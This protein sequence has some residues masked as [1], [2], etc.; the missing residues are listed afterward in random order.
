MQSRILL[1]IDNEVGF[2]QS[3]YPGIGGV[4]VYTEK[5]EVG[6]RWYDAHG[7]APKYAFGHGLS[8][9]TFAYS[10]LA[11]SPGEVSFTVS[12]AGDVSG[13]EVPQLYLGF[14][15]AAKEPPRQLKGFTKTKILAP[16]ESTAVKFSLTD[17][18]LSVWDVGTHGWSKQTGTFQV[19]V[20]ASS[21]DVRLTGSFSA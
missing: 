16:G 9:T 3:Q 1:H 2:T 17:R 14:P 15:P 18:D 12:N 19:F 5:L 13:A 8:Y 21:R 7:V 4:S 10:D 20:G 11:A 6:Y